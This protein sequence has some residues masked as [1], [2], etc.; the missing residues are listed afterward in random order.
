LYWRA[1]IGFNM[2]L[3]DIPSESGNARMY[4]LAAHGVMMVCDAAASNAHAQVFAPQC[5]AIYYESFEGAI[6]LIDHYLSHDEERLRIARNGFNRFWRDY[7]WDENLKKL[8]DWAW[9]LRALVPPQ[10]S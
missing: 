8:L 2:H 5:E 4:E 6:K 3:S 10:V 7:S 1:K 9:S